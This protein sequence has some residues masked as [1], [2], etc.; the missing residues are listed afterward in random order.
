MQKVIVPSEIAVVS[1]QLF[2]CLKQIRNNLE[3]I[4]E[5]Q[6]HHETCIKALGQDIELIRKMKVGV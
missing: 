6:A 5:T 4:R 1:E 2:A 3:V